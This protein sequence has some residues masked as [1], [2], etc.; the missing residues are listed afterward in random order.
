MI[1]YDIYGRVIWIIWGYVLENILFWCFFLRRI[2]NEG[3]FKGGMCW[4][5][6]LW[7]INCYVSR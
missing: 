4:G 1:L 2:S 7:F 3:R 5:K 6:I